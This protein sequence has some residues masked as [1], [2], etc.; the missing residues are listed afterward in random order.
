[1]ADKIPL[2]LVDN[3][4]GS[5]SITEFG[6][7]DTVPVAQGGTGGNTQLTAQAALGLVKQAS[8]TDGTAGSLLSVGAF[9]LGVSYTTGLQLL[10]SADSV[11]PTGIYRYNSA[12]VSKPGFGSGFGELL[13][14]T[15]ISSSG[16]YGNQLA[17]DYAADE[18]GFR[19]ISGSGWLPWNRLFHSANAVGTV[20]QG[21]LV[22]TGTNA[23]GTYTKFIDG[24]MICTSEGSNITTAS[25]AAN[26]TTSS[27]ITMPAAFIN[28]AFSI[29]ASAYPTGYWDHY[30]VV[31]DRKSVV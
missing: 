31:G 8:P 11:A 28:G 9:G 29:A 20:A 14:L 10:A 2:K 1:M 25:I 7:A 5:G 3:G 16:N 4:S 24:T 22:E 12:T 19:R 21:A 17:V 6:S 23:N 30:G 13:N 26:A 18:M 27:A 15:A